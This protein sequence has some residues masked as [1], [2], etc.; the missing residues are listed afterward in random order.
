M[1][2][3][4]PISLAERDEHPAGIGRIIAAG[5]REGGVGELWGKR[6]GGSAA[7]VGSF[8]RQHLG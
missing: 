3:E 7:L 4:L 5:G 2:Q 8:E 6:A 1:A